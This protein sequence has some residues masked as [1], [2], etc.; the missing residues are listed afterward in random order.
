VFFCSRCY[1]KIK[2]PGDYTST[3]LPEWCRP[4]EEIAVNG[5]NESIGAVEMQP[6][7]VPE[8]EGLP[9]THVNALKT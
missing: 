1:Q 6:A 8:L 2:E 5:V 9:T 4:I 3:D 7:I